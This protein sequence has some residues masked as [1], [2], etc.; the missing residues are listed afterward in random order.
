M[1]KYFFSYLVNPGLKEESERVFEGIGKGR[2]RELDNWFEDKWLQLEFIKDSVNT[3]F[4]SSQKLDFN[5]LI[6]ILSEKREQFKEFSELFIVNE[7]GIVNISTAKVQIGKNFKDEV[8]FKK[9]IKGEK[10]MY[11]PYIDPDTLAVGNCHSDFFDE[12]TLMFAFPIYNESTRRNAVICGRIPNDVMSDII[13]EEDTHVYKESGDNY[14]FM[15]KNNRNIPVGTAISRSRFEDNAFTLGDNLKDGIKT[16][17]WGTVRINKHTEF[18]IVFNDPATNELHEGVANTI[19]NGSNLEAWPGYPEYRHILVGGKGILIHPPHSDEVWGMMCEGDIEEIFKFKSL[20]NKLPFLLSISS[21]LMMVIQFLFLNTELTI[22]N[23]LLQSIPWLLNIILV[24]FMTRTVIVKPLKKVIHI[25][26]EVAEGGGDLTLRVPKSSNDEI[27]EISRWFNKFLSSQMM[28]IKRAGIVSKTSEDSAKLLSDMSA[29]IQSE[30]PAVSQSVKQ[31]IENLNKQN[32]VFDNTKD[33]FTKLT[34]ESE[35][36]DSSITMIDESINNTN[37]NAIKSIESSQEVLNT[38]D[39][40][41]EEMV[42]ATNSIRTLQDYSKK[43]NEVVITIDRI[44]KQTQLLALNATIES[45]RAGEAGKGF[46]VVA[47]EISK[48]AL[49]CAEATISIGHLISDVQEE[50]EHTATNIQEIAHKVEAGS[51]SVKGTINT[52]G[53]IQKEIMEVSKTAGKISSL[54]RS[55]SNDFIK[56]NNDMDTITS[57]LRADNATVRGSSDNVL[58]V[59]DHI[60]TQTNEIKE[61]SKMLFVTSTNLNNIVDGFIIKN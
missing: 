28:T 29:D 17:K 50:T 34:R 24:A 20:N 58:Y 52:F 35:V 33:Q 42:R 60:F 15:V 51:D 2:Q 27:G 13:Q 40:L 25:L 45:A 54:V 38:M 6:A 59:I 14:L 31:I 53:Y 55:Q 22:K 3:F 49:D 47:E 1:N 8:Y 5:K 36:I 4:E 30:A 9:A 19:K 61:L 46:A 18:E 11:G 37:E 21:V 26:Q 57:E 16:K 48:L 23:T 7:E 43:I 10:Y 41:K 39:T 56:I 44:A 12:V 32:S